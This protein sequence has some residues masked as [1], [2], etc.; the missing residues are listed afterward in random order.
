[1]KQLYQKTLLAII[2]ALISG[3][4]TYWQTDSKWLEITQTAMISMLDVQV[5]DRAIEICRDKELQIDKKLDDLIVTVNQW[6]G[7]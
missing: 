6:C 4:G 7:I 2:P 3:V 5:D 1:M